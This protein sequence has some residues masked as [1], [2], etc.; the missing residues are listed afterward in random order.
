MLGFTRSKT[1][2]HT[3][4]H[5]LFGEFELGA[6]GHQHTSS[7]ISY[8][9]NTPKWDTHFTNQMQCINIFHH[10]NLIQQI[11][12]HQ[13]KGSNKADFIIIFI[14]VN[15]MYYLHSI[16]DKVKVFS[17]GYVSQS[18][19]SF[20]T[21]HFEKKERLKD[22]QSDEY[23]LLQVSLISKIFSSPYLISSTSSN[24]NKWVF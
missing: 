3:Q 2:T 9:L 24:Y 17:F 18:L 13:K 10:T 8:Q 12:S 11:S 1:H 21:F 7:L 5:G 19:L 14:K 15:T 23:Y 6:N 22:F 16:I 20:F 4:K